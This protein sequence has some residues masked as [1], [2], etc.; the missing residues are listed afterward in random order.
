MTPVHRALRGYLPVRPSRSAG[1]EPQVRE[2]PRHK[3][4]FS[5]MKFASLS[6]CIKGNGDAGTPGCRPSSYMIQLLSTMTGFGVLDQFG[7]G[8]A[9]LEC[10]CSLRQHNAVLTGA[11]DD[12]GHQ[13]TV[14]G[15]EDID[16][17]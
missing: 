12:G 7:A 11:A 3:I 5:V 6:V 10:P 15:R 16:L 2:S 17:G 9:L 4:A 8:N 14:E 1:T 13:L